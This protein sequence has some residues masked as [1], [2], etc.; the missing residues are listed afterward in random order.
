[1]EKESDNILIRKLI[2]ELRLRKY[3]SETEKSYTNIIKDFLKSEKHTRDFLLGYSDKSRSYN[4]GIYF[5]LKFFYENV[6]NEKLYDK[7]PLVKA[8]IKIP[9]VLSKKEAKKIIDITDNLRHKI[10]LMLLYYAGLRLD[11]VLNLD[12]KD[13]DF[14]RGLI[15]L[16]KT[17]GEYERIV[18]LH[19]NLKQALGIYGIKQGLVLMSDRNKKYNKRSIQQ[20]VKNSA[21]KA[22][23][24]KNVHPHTLRHSFATHL[25]EAGCDI[26]YIQKLLGHKNLQTTQIYT[27]IANK[28]IKRLANLL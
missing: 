26:R 8:K 22:G 28:D 20:I 14:D 3:S 1:M 16:K 15:H 25:L 17:K 18:F 6:L 7:L 13:I 12:W 19:E 11:E 10:A 27:H 9:V 23:I 5:A 24:K 21:M 4:R 2:E